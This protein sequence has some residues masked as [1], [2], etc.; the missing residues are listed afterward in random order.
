[1]LD[2]AEHLIR[3]H[4]FN[5]PYYLIRRTVIGPIL[6]MYKL[7]LRKIEGFAEDDT[8]SKRGNWDLIQAWTS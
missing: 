4:S 7:R 1:M 6:Q 8:M 2:S 3:I 5:P